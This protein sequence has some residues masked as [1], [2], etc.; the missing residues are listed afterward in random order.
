MRPVSLKQ[1]LAD[2]LVLR[3]AST[4]ADVE[5]AAAFNGLIHSPELE[6]AVYDL[7]VHY[8]GIDLDDLIFVE[9]E[10]TGQIVS[11]LLLIPWTITLVFLSIRM[12]M[13]SPIP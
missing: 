13:I 11:S 2:S 7:I 3:T 4:L 8:P 5:R 10:G 6:P 1:A 9:D 12:L